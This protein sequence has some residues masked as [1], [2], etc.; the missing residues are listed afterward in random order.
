MVFVGVNFLKR[1]GLLRLPQQ[2]AIFSHFSCCLAFPP[3]PAATR[4]RSRTAFLPIEMQPSQISMGDRTNRGPTS[5]Q[6][7]ASEAYRV[8]TSH[9]K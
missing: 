9:G 5:E 1:P 8:E 4:T 7:G 6:E 3:P 2:A